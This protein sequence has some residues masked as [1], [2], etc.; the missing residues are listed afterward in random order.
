MSVKAWTE[1]KKYLKKE[2]KQTLQ[3]GPYFSYQVLNTPRHFLISMSRYKFVARMLPQNKK[4]KVL[5]LGCQE[6][7]G[8]L[9]LA[10]AGHQVLGV[11]FDKDAILHAQKSIKKNNICFQEVDFMGK[12]FGKFQAVVSLDVIEHINTTRQDAFLKTVCAN[13]CYKGFALIGTPNITAK[14]YASR[15]SRTGHVNLYSYERLDALLRKYFDNIF[16]FGMNDEVVHTGF[17]PMCHYLIALAC[18]VKRIK[19]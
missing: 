14:K 16:I 2:L 19:L 4:I 18:G 1:V 11:D 3:L 10:E 8:T 15:Q 13:L 6:G 17:Y 7:V 12:R 5:E 9:I